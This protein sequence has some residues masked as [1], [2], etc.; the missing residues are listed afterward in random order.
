[1]RPKCCLLISVVLGFS[2]V[3]C[4]PGVK[5]L[6]DPLFETTAGATAVALGDINGDGL[7][8]VASISKESQPVQIHLRN[9]ITMKF[10]T[11]TIAGG[12]PLSQANDIELA[13]LNSD[14][15]LDIVVL[16]N[17]TGFV[18]PEGAAKSGAIVMLVQGADP[19]VP[20]D[21]TQVPTPGE[22]APDNLSF[23]SDD[24]GVTDLAVGNLDGWTGPDIVVL[25]NEDEKTNVYLYSNPGAASVTDQ[26]AW[27]PSVIEAD[28][29]P[30]GQ[31]KVSD[32]D[33][34]GDVDIVL[35]VPTAKSFNLRW[36]QNPLVD[37][38][39]ATP[40][41]VPTFTPSNID[42]AYEV[43]AGAKAT[44]AGDL[45]NDGWPDLA[46]ISDESQPVQVHLRDPLTSTFE[47]VTIAGGSLLARPSVIRMADLNGDDKQDLIVLVQ[48]TGSGGCGGSGT[49]DPT[50]CTD[51]RGAL[52][53]LIQG[54][55]PSV[56]ADWTQVPRTT[57]S[58]SATFILGAEATDVVVGDMDG[59]NGP[60]IVVLSNENPGNELNAAYLFTNPGPAGAADQTAW[61]RTWIEHDLPA[62][63]KM[64][65][66]DVDGDGDLDVVLGAP[67]AQS[68]NVR[69]LQN[70]LVQLATGA[71]NPIPTFVPDLIDPLLE[72]TAGAKTTVLGDV[73]ADGLLDIVSVSDESQ[74]VQLHLRNALTGKFDTLSIAGG[75]PLA[76]SVDLG[77]GDFDMDGRMDIAVLVND[78]SYT[79]PE[80]WKAQKVGALVLLLQGADPTDP[81]DWFQVDAADSN[82]RASPVEP[83]A[84]GTDMMLPGNTAGPLSL[85]VADFD[86]DGRS[87]IA[88]TSNEPNDPGDP[89]IPRRFVKL[90][91]NPGR[92]GQSSADPAN[93]TRMSIY[94]TT[95]DLNQVFS[96][97]LDLDDDIDVVVTSPTAK[98]HNISWLQNTGNMAVWTEKM[99]AQ[100]E[101]GAGAIAL[102]DINGDGS[103][104]VAAASA[105]DRLTQWFVNPGPT[106]LAPGTAQ[107][108]WYVFNIGTLDEGDINQVRLVD[109]DN[110]GTLDC[111]V[112]ASG[113][114]YGFRRQTD[115]E[116]VWDAFPIFRSDPVAT[117]GG[118]SFADFDGDGK[119]DVVAP[120]N[121]DG[122]VDDRFVLYKSVAASLWYRRLIGQ[123]QGGANLVAAG[124]ID[125]DGNP[126]VA[127][128]SA[129]DRLAQWF[130][131]P[132]S[133]VVAFDAPQV[134]WQVY[135]IGALAAG[136]LNQIQLVDLDN[137]ATRDCFVTASGLGYGFRR[138][139]NVQ[140]SWD[141]FFIT[142]TD[143]VAV[144][145]QT[146]FADFT[147]DGRID[148]VAPLNADGLTGDR[149]VLYT[150]VTASLWQRRLIGQQQDG[151]EC[152]SVGDIDGDGSPDLLAASATYGVAQWL[153]NPGPLSL[154]PGSTQV[155][156]T[157]YTIGQISDID[158]DGA[159]G[160]GSINQ[161]HLVDMD[162]D[163]RLDVFLTSDD[164]AKGG[165]AFMYTQLVD[166][167]STWLGS[168]LFTTD[169]AG[170]LGTAGFM[171][172]DLNG[173]MDIIVPVNRAGLISDDVVLFVR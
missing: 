95:V 92:L 28:A 38:G 23:A 147:R 61:T 8:D 73:N 58:P 56:P 161:A 160:G 47:T 170:Q 88:L 101:G 66:T 102:G 123:Q 32:L 44:A 33:G 130:K 52:V 6:V 162:G 106:A 35:S 43:S 136:T 74:P 65:L 167:R 30:L 138:Q 163:G 156:W 82:W 12:A 40:N 3:A 48:S 45:N 96:T 5:E 94:A 112:T 133:T 79:P 132:G 15:K 63:S 139:A 13:D 143:P 49:T 172:V 120:F 165:V 55:D 20:G 34:D 42:P 125:A 150:S 128:A 27:T 109:L 90:F 152:I 108:P 24:L 1:M 91:L 105:A 115:V 137:N 7:T 54:A 141:S 31:V 16:V 142:A 71:A 103:V 9:P 158:V 135:T 18:P 118:A 146:A 85:T 14:G 68:F 148:F 22:P 173:F 26:T 122:L 157:T 119:V 80:A 29:A 76:K 107:V 117:I 72:V 2:A 77:L 151:G 104:D 171:D 11:Y 46:S 4:V 59:A 78:T 81:N 50:D 168:P 83:P 116:H 127:V 67:T 10:D 21:W 36:L 131:N 129:A 159:A 111:F 140:H 57:E 98:S 51:N 53:L 37:L 110:N 84:A 153:K 164:E 145:G 17:D 154:L 69:W 121:R 41:P 25:S 155:P 93:W 39:S 87:D 70:P 113:V 62:L 100:Q 114:G 99:I 89:S 75:A 169:P 60:D 144:I 149:I 124:D 64:D 97:D 134:P 166:P 126:D 19:T 86:Q